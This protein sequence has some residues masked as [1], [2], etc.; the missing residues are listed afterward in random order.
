M[1]FRKQPAGV[2]MGRSPVLYIA[3]D[4]TAEA[5]LYR[6]NLDVY[7]WEGTIVSV[8]ASP[9]YTLSRFPDALG[10]AVF[11]IS[12][13]TKA[14]FIDMPFAYV[15]E[16]TNGM[17]VNVLCKASYTDDAGT[18]STPVSSN[19]IQVQYGY[20]HP[21]EGA[22]YVISQEDDGL[23]TDTP[24]YY[25][26]S[27]GRLRLY[28]R[29]TASTTATALDIED[30]N[31]LG[32][33]VPF[34]TGTPV[35]SGDTLLAFEVGRQDL[36]D[37]HGWTSSG[38]YYDIYPK[39]AGGS[40]VGRTIRYYIEDAC[41]YPL[42]TIDFINRYG[43]WDN[44]YTYGETKE[45]MTIKKMSGV[46]HAATYDASG[47]VTYLDGDGQYIDFNKSGMNEFIIN[48]GWLSETYQD[49]LEQLLLSTRIMLNGVAAKLSDSS[50]AYKT[51][52]TDKMINYTFKL[53]SAYNTMNNVT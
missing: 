25:Q 5:N 23:L 28:V 32:T 10:H 4:A 8:P 39:N 31:A 18:T 48:T 46:R 33:S 43:V 16:A 44:I 52:R 19:T 26:P 40:P 30:E 29:N 36:I 35:T 13:L 15:A 37:T 12:Q 17:A 3:Y 1:N 2:M 51:V 38:S 34:T 41:R 9:T 42:N 49:T 50:I 14:E 53:T 21:S 45:S 24:F 27:N 47:N 20:T 11:N 22:N 7:I 6:Y